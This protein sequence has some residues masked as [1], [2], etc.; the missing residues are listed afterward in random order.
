MKIIS[1][2]LKN[3]TEYAVVQFKNVVTLQV[4]QDVI[5]FYYCIYQ[6]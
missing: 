4:V 6:L 3:A 2:V 5:H 1:K